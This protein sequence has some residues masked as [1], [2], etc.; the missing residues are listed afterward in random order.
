MN[1]YGVFAEHA[2]MMTRNRRQAL[3]LA[4]QYHGEVRSMPEPDAAYWDRPTFRLCSHSI[5]KYN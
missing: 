1:L 2:W 5:A 4:K 3:R